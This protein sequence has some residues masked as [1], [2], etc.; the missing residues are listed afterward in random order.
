MTDLLYHALKKIYLFAALKLI[1]KPAIEA[2]L[3][4]LLAFRKANRTA[5]LPTSEVRRTHLSSN[6]DCKQA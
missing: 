6:C 3:A 2:Y 1:E 4:L 5:V